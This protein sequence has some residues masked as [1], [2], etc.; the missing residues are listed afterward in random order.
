MPR[1]RPLRRG[2]VRGHVRSADD[3]LRERMPKHVDGSEQLRRMR[4]P[5]PV[6]AEVHGRRVRVTR[7]ELPRA[8]APTR[9]R[10]KT[11]NSANRGN[12]RTT[13]P[14]MTMWLRTPVARLHAATNCR[15]RPTVTK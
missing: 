14:A 7:L 8:D 10:C 5:L 11:A 6:R 3:S 1:G 12:D 2:R 15:N 9:C 13:L 4:R